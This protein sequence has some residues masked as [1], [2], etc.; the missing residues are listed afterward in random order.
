MGHFLEALYEIG[1]AIIY[2]VALTVGVLVVAFSIAWW[3]QA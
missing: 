3:V 1:K 2:G